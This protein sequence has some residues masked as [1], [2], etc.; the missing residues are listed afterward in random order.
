MSGRLTERECRA[1]GTLAA[2]VDC[3]RVRVHRAG[4]TGVRGMLR[5]AVLALSR[6]R[7][8]ALGNHI[9]LPDRHAHDLAVLAHEVTH[10]GQYQ[11]WGAL[12][13]FSRGAVTQV[14]DLLYRTARLGRCPYRYT[15]VPGQPFQAYGMEQ[16]GQIVEDSFRGDPVAQAISPFHPG[17]LV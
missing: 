5:S 15:A 1:L 6:G 3:S 11:R 9:F 2:S 14:R 17:R 12:S 8:V 16:Q 10:A 13:Y 7:A 4:A